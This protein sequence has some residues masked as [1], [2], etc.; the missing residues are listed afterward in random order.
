M[1]STVA[2]QIPAVTP[3]IATAFRLI[4]RPAIAESDMP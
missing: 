3:H 1:S 2:R 4:D